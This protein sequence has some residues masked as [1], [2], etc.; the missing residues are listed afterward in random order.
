VTFTD[1]E[2]QKEKMSEINGESYFTFWGAEPSN[3][4]SYRERHEKVT[5]MLIERHGLITEIFNH[6]FIYTLNAS[7]F[8]SVILNRFMCVSNNQQER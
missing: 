5:D 2:A 4:Q 6:R 1:S 8:L 7:V 3:L